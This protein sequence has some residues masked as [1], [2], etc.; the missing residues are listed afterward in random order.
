MKYQAPSYWDFDFPDVLWLSFEVGQEIADWL[1]E[2][3]GM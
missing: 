2:L 1:L 3:L